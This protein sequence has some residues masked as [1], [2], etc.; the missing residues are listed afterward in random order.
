MPKKRAVECPLKLH[1]N[2]QWYKKFKGK[3]HYFGTDRDTALSRWEKEGEFVL[4]GLPIP[5]TDGAPSVV[6]LGNLFVDSCKK[7]LKDGDIGQRSIEDYERTIKRMIAIVGQHCRPQHMAP[8]D[9]ASLRERLHEPTPRTKAIQGGLKGRTVDR[10]SPTTVTGDIRRI[11]TFLRWCSDTELIPPARF[12]REFKIA[13]ASVVRKIRAK[14]GPQDLTADEIKSVLAKASRQL[15]PLVLLG[16]NSAMG[17]LD[18]AQMT[19]GDVALDVPEVWVDLPRNKTG[20]PR[21]FVLWPETVVAI[22]SYLAKRANPA[23]RSNTDKLFL[24]RTGLQWSTDS[25]SGAFR[26]ARENAGVERGNFYDLRRTFQ[27]Q[28]ESTLDFPAIS[29]IMGHAP[30]SGD[31]A[32]RYRQRIDDDRIRKVCSHVRDWLFSGVAQ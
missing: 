2:G 16:I 14:Q 10:L 11:R 24:T 17:N 30:K 15:K 31:M 20:F 21:R 28:A 19:F 7:R 1:G 27:T 3:M 23:G 22:K 29:H 25:L 13:S 9:F 6:E 5:R 4:A 26:K 8:A 32:S 18:I 12:G